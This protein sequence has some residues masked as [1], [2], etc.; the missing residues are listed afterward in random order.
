M[1][2]YSQSFED[3]KEVKP[4]LNDRILPNL[5]G[6]NLKLVPSLRNR[7]GNDPLTYK[8]VYKSASS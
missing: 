8:L 4:W 2:G 3:H 1:A 6:V 7:L 5:A